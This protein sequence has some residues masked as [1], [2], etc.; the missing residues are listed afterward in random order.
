MIHQRRSLLFLNFLSLIVSLQAFGDPCAAKLANVD[1]IGSMIV[2]IDEA[3]A[4]KQTDEDFEH[5]M[6]NDAD[7]Q[8]KRHDASKM[9][10]RAAAHHEFE[11]GFY[12]GGISKAMAKGD[13]ET[14]TFLGICVGRRGGQA[15]V[16][17]VAA[18]QNEAGAVQARQE[19][20]PPNVPDLNQL[21]MVTENP[22]ILRL[23]TVPELPGGAN[24]YV[25]DMP[26]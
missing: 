11:K 6:S 26:H 7:A 25:P 9:L 22:Q 17:R 15:G 10:E 20:G 19:D 8:L 1:G 14:A 16:D 2:G 18:A 21:A 23:G 13:I 12:E 3:N 4:K 5:A 24:H